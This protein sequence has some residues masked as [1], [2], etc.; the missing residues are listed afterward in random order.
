M[1]VGR[2][3]SPSPSSDQPVAKR[4]PGKS[5]EFAANETI[6][7][8]SLSTTSK[9]F[10][11]L[12]EDYKM[13]RLGFAQPK[14]PGSPP[15]LH[16]IHGGWTHLKD[17]LSL[18]P[19]VHN[20]LMR[21]I[22]SSAQSGMLLQLPSD[23]LY[24]VS[25]F[26]DGRS[27]MALMVTC[28][29]L[30]VTFANDDIWWDICRALILVFVQQHTQW[31]YS[32]SEQE[33]FTRMCEKNIIWWGAAD[34]FT[35]SY[36][37]GLADDCVPDWSAKSLFYR[38]QAIRQILIAM[39]IKDPMSQFRE[40]TTADYLLATEEAFLHQMFRDFHSCPLL[41]AV[42]RMMACL[43]GNTSVVGGGSEA[44]TQ[45][46][47]LSRSKHAFL[48]I[49]HL[50]LKELFVGHGPVE[51][52]NFLAMGR[53][54]DSFNRVK[55]LA[56]QATATFVDLPRFNFVSLLSERSTRSC[57]CPLNGPNVGR[58]YVRSSPRHFPVYIKKIGQTQ[59]CEVLEAIYFDDVSY[60]CI[61][62]ELDRNRP[63]PLKF[64]H[65]PRGFGAGSM[66]EM[67]DAASLREV[68]FHINSMYTPGDDA[69]L[70]NNSAEETLSAIVNTIQ[71]S[72]CKPVWADPVLNTFPTQSG[73]IGMN[74]YGGYCQH[75]GDV[76]RSLEALSRGVIYNTLQSHSLLKLLSSG[77]SINP[78]HLTAKTLF[79]KRDEPNCHVVYAR[80]SNHK[81]FSVYQSPV[82]S[83][84]CQDIV[85]ARQIIW[86]SRITL[87]HRN[88][89]AIAYLRV[90]R[91]NAEQ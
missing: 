27:I 76:T 21:P 45:L 69:F 78:Q 73:I 23:V 40:L 56:K 63:G 89:L 61:L 58:H 33:Q 66:Q 26:L 7:S 71:C 1:S 72:L 42:D 19:S 15:R 54:V 43:S 79:I 68:S 46:S 11:D 50:M 20:M 83:T 64:C 12:A 4:Q 10:C 9:T 51:A 8:D 53:L 39:N 84:I 75:I 82:R 28:R 57:L 24:H 77:A 67:V 60:Q 85:A 55:L 2:K 14:T 18:A 65:F 62:S 30:F 44:D 41:P 86:F 13:L 90:L 74:C 5:A 6:I 88:H 25:A 59:T 52:P 36:A 49:S 47:T 22:Q 3:R 16:R 17:S 37:M 87:N 70:L 48:I 80:R 31:K 35:D 32:I 81:V 29:S 38:K 34:L 91:R